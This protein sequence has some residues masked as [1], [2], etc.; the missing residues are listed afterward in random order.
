VDYRLLGPLE[1]RDDGRPVALGAAKERALLALLLLHRGEVV[2]SERLIDGLW[3]EHP[4][5]TAAKSLQVH[6]SHLRKA[7]GAGPIVTHGHGYVLEAAPDEVDVDRFECAAEAGRRLF[8]AGDA[9]RAAAKLGEALQMWRGP[10]LADFAYEPFAETEA[11]RLAELRIAALEDRIDADLALGRHAALVAELEALVR[12]HSLRERLRGQLMLALYRCGRQADALERYREGREALVGELGL[13]PGR[14]LRGLEEAILRQDPELDGPRRAR[15]RAQARRRRRSGLVMAA[16]GAALL[17]VAVAAAVTGLGGGGHARRAPGLLAP[18]SVG[19]IDPSTGQVVASVPVPG[20]PDRLAVRG[21]TVWAVADASRTLTPIDAVHGS[22]GASLSPGGTPSDVATNR[23][24]IWVLNQDAPASVT[25]L[26]LG[27]TRPLGSI[28][29]P[30]LAVPLAPRAAGGSDAWTIAAGPEAAW[31]TDGSPRLTRIDARTDVPTRTDLGVSVDAV[32][33]D[34]GEV[35]AVSGPQ[36]TAVRVDP[37]DGRPTKAIRIAGRPG[38]EASFPL[39]VEIG[40]GAV[41]VLNGNTATVTRID[42]RAG[43][44]AATIPIGIDHGPLSLATGAG[45]VWVAGTDG[46]VSKIDPATNRV[47]RVFPVAHGALDVTVA[48]RRVWVSAALGLAPQVG[49]RTVPLAGPRGQSL[50]PLRSPSCSIPD[51]A[52]G[53]APRL[54]VVSDMPLQDVQATGG[55]QITEAIRETLRRQQFRAGRFAIAYQACDDTAADGPNVAKCRTQAHLYARDPSVVAVIGPFDSPCTRAELPILNGAPQG[56]LV[57]VGESSTYVGLTRRGPGTR[58][59]EPARY[60]RSGTRSYVRVVPPDNVQAAA[61]ADLAR[62]FGVRRVYVLNDAYD[63]GK[64]IA[65]LFRQAAPRAGIRVVGTGLMDDPS[66]AAVRALAHRV[67]A[68]RADGVFLGAYNLPAGPPLIRALRDALPSLRLLAPDGFESSRIAALIGA[69]GEGLTVSIPGRP[70]S[71]LPPAGARFARSFG[72]LIGVR[73]IPYA[74]YAAQATEVLLDAIAR[75]DGTRASIVRALFATRMHNSLLG[76]FGFTRSGDI[77]QR[78]I[79]VYRIR[80]GA[81]RLWKVV[82]PPA[83]L[84]DP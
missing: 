51:G 40:F 56:T 53:A 65:A 12:A 68:S 37:R 13:E 26:R 60:A 22:A 63:Y 33:A 77:T 39:A 49:R 15:A 74:V 66:P 30:R 44:V 81:L 11:A 75:S 55:L 6:V 21:A 41:W 83:T 58:R 78:A 67:V 47:V 29:L 9:E 76:S 69:Q 84:I 28:P 70:V 54:L 50:Q 5:A 62:R 36:A 10:P 18:D 16:G 34:A 1:V 20:A 24:T 7:L 31:V 17:L 52:P 8:A 82:T 23:S 2:S 61:D 71:A 80:D 3:G 46:T 73:P 59:D 4:P 19:A 25:K 38:P 64:G 72:A 32:A 45:A 42:P 14:E 27:Y 43:A 35:W 48:G 79:A 57:A